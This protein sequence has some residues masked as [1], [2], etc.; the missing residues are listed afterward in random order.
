MPLANAVGP[1]T[2]V[3][4]LERLSV[5]HAAS[6][7]TML[8]VNMGAGYIVGELYTYGAPPVLVSS[9]TM[10][11]AGFSSGGA[12]ASSP[13]QDII[14]R[15]SLRI[16]N[17]TKAL[18]VG[19]AVRILRVSA[20]IEV[21]GGAMTQAQADSIYAYVRSNPR[22]RTFG[23]QELIATHQFNSIPVNQ[24]KLASFAQSGTNASG[25]AA[26]LFDPAVSS[27]VILF[28]D[29]ST[30]QDYEVTVCGEYYTRYRYVG[31]LAHMARSPKTAPLHSINAAREKEESQLS[32]GRIVTGPTAYTM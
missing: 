4:G 12:S 31:P 8:L 10:D 7:S 20:G 11:S 16:R 6:S 24:S 15:A 2:H 30:S 23:G 1:C 3:R 17:T 9:L 18:D 19:G 29:T 14:T 28:E 13:D 21:T 32:R 27:F 26:E 5:A 25:F 22:T